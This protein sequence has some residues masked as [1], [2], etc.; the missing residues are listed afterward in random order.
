M[1]LPLPTG[2]LYKLPHS[3]WPDEDD[4]TKLSDS[5]RM[6]RQQR[7]YHGQF[8]PPL[9]R[10]DPSE[11]DHNVIDNRCEP[12]VSTGVDFV[13]G[14]DLGFE[15]T[16]DDGTEDPEA[17][18]Y[19][20]ATWEANTKM[21]TLAE[22]EIN[23]AIYGHG[24]FKVDPDDEDTAPFP[25]ISILNP[26]QM[27]VTT[28]PTDVRKVVRYCFTYQDVDID[29][30]Q[31]VMRRTLWLRNTTGVTDIGTGRGG[32]VI[33]EQ[34]QEQGMPTLAATLTP[35]NPT[36]MA[37]AD[38]GWYD[39]LEPLPW[40]YTWGP[41]HDKK[42]LPEPNSYWGKADLRLDLVHLNDRLNFLLSNRQR[43][44]YFHGHPKDVFFG[45]HAREIDVSPAGAICI[46][47]IAAKVQHLE[48]TG[49]LAAIE[50]AIEEIR[51]SMDELSHVPSVAVGRLKNLPG[52]PSGV[53]MK[54]AYRPLIS[55]TLQKRALREA[56]LKKLNQHI[57]E[58]GGYGADRKV[59]LHWANMLPSDDLGVA[60]AAAIWHSIGASTDS[61]LDMGPFDPAVEAEKRK[62]EAAEAAAEAAKN[63]PPPPP[64]PLLIAAPD[65]L[66]AGQ[67][68]TPGQQ[69][70]VASN[71]QQP[72]AQSK[73]PAVA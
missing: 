46:P 8:K 40:P 4:W 37:N 33:R 29:K 53:S 50:Q 6:E 35:L 60:Q 30:Q 66:P 41:I 44:L 9:R 73:Q 43:I 61:C 67:S 34:Q 52:V 45:I 58:L 3:Q 64:A 69:P 38:A 19:L 2:V 10:M 72:A 54:V 11:P 59:I 25:G 15:V 49:N 28:S 42:N 12:I 68:Q 55:Q 31:T 56:M 1:G 5:E 51:E 48:M 26:Q 22:Y 62:E 18:A 27:S 13:Y 24:F 16:E 32:W 7:A 21:P 65:A 39:I 63:A 36:A 14:D 23:S 70:A 20:D 47:N 71:G 17:Q 57:L